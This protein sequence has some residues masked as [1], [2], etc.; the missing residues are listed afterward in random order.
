V[1]ALR[2]ALTR[3]ATDKA[4]RD[5]ARPRTRELA[6]GHTPAA[7]ADAVARLARSLVDAES[8]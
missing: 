3:V 1:E 2:R 6:R 5:A 4:F 8:G 7:W